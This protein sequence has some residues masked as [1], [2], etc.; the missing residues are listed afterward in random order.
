MQSKLNKSE[1]KVALEL[2]N[3]SRATI[4]EI[5]KRTKLTRQTVHRIIKDLKNRG[6]IKA[7]SAEPKWQDMGIEWKAYILTRMAQEGSHYQAFENRVS[8]M[9]EI[10]QMHYVLGQYDLIMEV[11][12]ESRQKLSALIRRLQAMPEIKRTETILTYITIKDE[13]NEPIKAV[14]EKQ[15][16]P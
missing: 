12:V 7:Y 3:D 14:L 9:P 10:S 11:M 6:I 15:I 13:L 5:A 2:L 4:S 1:A 8:A 16:N